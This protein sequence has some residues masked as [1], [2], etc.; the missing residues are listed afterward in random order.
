[1]KPD[2]PLVNYS[3]YPYLASTEQEKIGNDRTGL[4]QYKINSA[5]FRGK[6]F[7]NIDL[8]TLGCSITFGIG[9]DQDKTWP[10]RLA[11]KGNLTVAN[12]SKPAGSP[13]TCFRFA[14]YWI[15]EL[16][17]KYVVY[18]QPPP[19]RLEILKSD[20]FQ[21]EQGQLT[22]NN[23]GVIDKRLYSMY[24]AWIRNKINNDLNYQKNKLAIAQLC[25]NN[26]IEFLSYTLEGWDF[27]NDL[28]HD[29]VHPGP[30]AN[31]RFATI[32]YSDLDTRI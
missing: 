4:V 25:T 6:D 8:I 18:L 12:L 27:K 29:D 22:I 1:M 19:G 24:N 26:N 21:R 11:E 14:S 7:E 23:T 31:E 9:V 10:Y 20:L 5:G 30:A 28:A 3:C 16:K 13:D 32:V 17:P 15:P 2:S